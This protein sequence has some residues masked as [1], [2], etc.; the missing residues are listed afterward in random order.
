MVLGACCSPHSRRMSW[1]QEHPIRSSPVDQS[2]MHWPWIRIHPFRACRCNPFEWLVLTFFSAHLPL[3]CRP[4]P[5]KSSSFSFFRKFTAKLKCQSSRSKTPNPSIASPPLSPPARR[6]SIPVAPNDL[7][8]FQR[9]QAAL[10]QCGLVPVP[11][12][13]LSQLERELD[14]KFSHVVVLPQEQP[15]QGEFTTAEKIR[16]EWQA[17]HEAQLVKQGGDVDPINLNNVTPD[18][19]GPVR[20]DQSDSATNTEEQSI[21]EATTASSPPL[22][23]VL[24]HNP[25][26]SSF[27]ESPEQPPASSPQQSKRSPPIHITITTD[28]AQEASERVTRDR[29]SNRYSEGSLTTRSSLPALSPTM[30]ASSFS[31]IQTPRDDERR[32]SMEAM[33]NRSGSTQSRTSR[34]KMASET[35]RESEDLGIV[36][37]TIPEGPEPTVNESKTWN[38]SRENS[39]TMGSAGFEAFAEK[40]KS[41]GIFRS[42]KRGLGST[43]SEPGSRWSAIAKPLDGGRSRNSTL[44]VS[45]ILRARFPGF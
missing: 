13:D 20:L 26:S 2:I 24:P 45:T 42:N 9:R 12:K 28:D 15:D 40:R 6:P 32:E 16:S 34:R 31:S 23:S 1:S 39:T 43:R 33:I 19:E 22:S 21:L 17:S 8:S 29:S 41:P 38:P 44:S 35:G 14:R 27:A 37:E 10:Q 11:K 5:A 18:S 36:H 7:A 4:R 30:T 3:N 25:P